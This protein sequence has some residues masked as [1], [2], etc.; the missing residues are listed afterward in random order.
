MA[1]PLAS[2]LAAYE[3][4]FRA[5]GGDSGPT[6]AGCEAALA[7]HIPELVPVHRQLTRLVGDGDRAAR[8]RCACRWVSRKAMR[9]LRR[10]WS[11]TSGESDAG[12][13]QARDMTPASLRN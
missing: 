11:A 13:A 3:T 6:R 9:P 5:R 7:E 2:L 4:W 12:V 8:F 1:R 10:Q